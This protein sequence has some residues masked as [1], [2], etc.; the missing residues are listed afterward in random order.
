VLYNASQIQCNRIHSCRKTLLPSVINIISFWSR[1]SGKNWRKFRYT[2]KSSHVKE[3]IFSWDINLIGNMNNDTLWKKWCV[4]SVVFLQD[5]KRTYG[6]FIWNTVIVDFT[7]DYS[8]E[9]DMDSVKNLGTLKVA[10]RSRMLWIKRTKRKN[11]AVKYILYC[12][13]V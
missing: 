2:L 10:V 6:N 12:N 3:E 8:V 5:Y 11:V 13:F 4:P 9:N 1:I 7:K